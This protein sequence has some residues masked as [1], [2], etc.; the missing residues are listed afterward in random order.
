MSSADPSAADDPRIV[1]LVGRAVARDQAAFAELYDLHLDRV[2]RY[3]YYRTANQTDAEDL[4]EQV[5]LQAWAAIERFRWRGKP[6]LAWLYTVAHN[7]VVDWRRRATPT[8]SLDDADNPIDVESTSATQAMSQWIDADLLANAIKRL[9]PEQQQVIT[10]KFLDGFDTARI[11]QLMDKR[12]GTIRAL[13]LRALQ[14]L[15]RELERQG[16]G[17]AA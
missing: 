8:R 11:A 4:T 12:E 3:M 14:S 13:Q 1:A 10:L 16:V 2:Y 7:V 9:T 5:F 6:F 17:L 15:R